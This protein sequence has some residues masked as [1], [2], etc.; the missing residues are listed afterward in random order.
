MSVVYRKGKVRW[1]NANNNI[2]DV[3]KNTKYIKN[4]LDY[5][6]DRIHRN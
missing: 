5:N 3:E 6:N 2:Y 1:Y 4:N